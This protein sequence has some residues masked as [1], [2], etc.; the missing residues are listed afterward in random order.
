MTL[1][2]VLSNSFPFVAAESLHTLFKQMCQYL[3][4]RH[5]YKLT[6]EMRLND[7]PMVQQHAVQQYMYTCILILSLTPHHLFKSANAFPISERQVEV[8]R[9]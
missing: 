1:V 2:T 3:A 7:L 8:V 5:K 6:G 9:G 4:Q